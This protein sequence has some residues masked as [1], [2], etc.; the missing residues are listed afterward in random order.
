MKYPELSVVRFF[1]KNNLFSHPTP[2]PRVIEFGCGS[3][4]NLR[5]FED[6]GWE[7]HGVDLTEN[8]DFQK[9]AVR[10][11]WNVKTHFWSLDLNNPLPNEIITSHYDVVLFPSVTYYLHPAA[12]LALLE[13]M[14]KSLKPGG[15][16]FLIERL[17][18][19]YRYG[20]GVRTGSNGF[21]LDIA[22]TGEFGMTIQFFRKDEIL[23]ALSEISNSKL[24]EIV[25]LEYSY[26]NLQ[27]D[28]IVRNSELVVWGKKT[29]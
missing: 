3:G 22:E 12:R 7:C 21:R 2:N 13:S 24:S 29:I 15:F 14:F 16:M 11:D 27:S 18:S 5:V 9:D 28:K 25:T 19:D 10:G 23:S 20:K 8:Q 1:F 26:E 4:H 6:H 17:D